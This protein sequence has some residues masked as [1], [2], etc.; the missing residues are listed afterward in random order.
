MITGLLM[1]AEMAMVHSLSSSTVCIGHVLTF[2]LSVAE[3]S[4]PLF[5]GGCEKWELQH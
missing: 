2:S 5:H 3:N 4:C 1:I